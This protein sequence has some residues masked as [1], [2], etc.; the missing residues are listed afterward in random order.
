MHSVII[1]RLRV[2]FTGF[3]LL[4]ARAAS[5]FLHYIVII[6]LLWVFFTVLGDSAQ[7]GSVNPRQ[8]TE[9]LK[10]NCGDPAIVLY[11]LLKLAGIACLSV[12]VGQNQSIVAGAIGDCRRRRLLQ[13]PQ[14][15]TGA[16]S[17]ID[18][19]GDCSVHLPL[20]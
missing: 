1:P 20:R 15:V 18:T 14:V 2:A 9:V 4:Q 12:T 8:K 19:A 13:A 5:S 17:I 6:G 16:A 7:R 10:I 3:L 11:I